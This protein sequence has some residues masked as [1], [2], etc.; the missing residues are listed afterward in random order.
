M[1]RIF[2]FSVFLFIGFV[3]IKSLAQKDLSEPDRLKFE[4]SFFEALKQKAIGNYD[5]AIEALE[6]CQDL[7]STEVSV[8]FELSKNIIGLKIILPPNKYST[9][10]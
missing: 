2:F 9:K 3:P 5:K 6:L 10:L 7:D 4:A 1:I 8:Q